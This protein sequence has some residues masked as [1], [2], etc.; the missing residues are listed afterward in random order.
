MDKFM[1]AFLQRLLRICG[2]SYAL[3][4][5]LPASFILKTCFRRFAWFVRGFLRFQKPVF[6]G[7]RVTIDGA[8]LLNVGPYVTLDPD[9]WINAIAEKPV[10]LGKAVRIGAY[11]RILCT[12]HFSK[13][14]RHFVMGDH[15]ACG[16]YCFF[17]AAGGIVIGQN[18]IMGQ[19]VSIHAQ[20]HVFDDLQVPI[21]HQATTEKGISIG[22]NCWIGAKVTILDGTSIGNG[23]VIA[24][25]AVVKGIFPDYAVIGGVPASIIKM[26][27][28]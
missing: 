17:G 1:I 7:P 27:N 3:D 15:S 24:A 20:D 12:A 25:G 2:K 4:A 28:G 23:C 11:S 10:T 5:S 8:A 21:Q 18:V 6:I 19:Y 9:V 26:R 22:D 13:R 14:G 16:E